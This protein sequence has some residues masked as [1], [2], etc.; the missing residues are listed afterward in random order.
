MNAID[1]PIVEEEE[2]GRSQPPPAP[3]IT[4][5]TAQRLWRSVDDDGIPRRTQLAVLAAITAGLA[6]VLVSLRR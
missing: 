4:T 1:A 6:A 3:M 2:E 5:T